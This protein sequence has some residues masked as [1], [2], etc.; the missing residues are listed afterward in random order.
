MDIC[1]LRDYTKS[2]VMRACQA[3][4][5]FERIEGFVE[6]V[7]HVLRKGRTLAPSFEGAMGSKALIIT[8]LDLQ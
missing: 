6:G 7:G 4:A 1:R 3:A 8:T 2:L 5:S